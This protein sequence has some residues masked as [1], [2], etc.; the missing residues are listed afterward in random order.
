MTT[1][2][3]GTRGAAPVPDLGGAGRRSS[4]TLSPWEVAGGD[5]DAEFHIGLTVPGAHFA[6]DT[7]GDHAHTRLELFDDTSGSWAAIDY[8]GR[9]SAEFTVTQAGAHP[10]WDEITAAYRQWERL[11]RPAVDRYGLT[12]TPDGATTAWLDAPATV[13]TALP[14]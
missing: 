12:V 6:W 13:M 8:D 1:P 2:T 14:A 7:S 10:L 11:G 4:T 3:T 9:T 5:L